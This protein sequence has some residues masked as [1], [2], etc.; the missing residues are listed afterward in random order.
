MLQLP[1]TNSFQQYHIL[2]SLLNFVQPSISLKFS[3]IKN[4]IFVQQIFK[5][6]H[7]ATLSKGHIAYIEVPITN[8]QPKYYHVNDLNNLAH[9]AAHTYNPDITEP[10]PISNYN[11][12]KK[13]IPSL[14][15]HFSSHQIYMTSFTLHD[16]PDSNIYY[17]QPTS[18]TPKSRT[19]PTLPYS[20]DNLR[21]INKP[22]FQFYDLNDTE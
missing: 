7:I 9:T 18:D 4:L 6:L 10:I 3:Q 22:N 12:P 13:D 14:L 17:V 20:K 21:F 8:E 16:T 2:T 15:N 5:T 11:T 19:F 1:G